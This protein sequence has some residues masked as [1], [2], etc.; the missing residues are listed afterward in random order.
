[1]KPAKTKTTHARKT[2]VAQPVLSVDQLRAI[3]GG[4][5]N[6]YEDATK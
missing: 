2:T 1:M 6:K 3:V 5:M 4:V